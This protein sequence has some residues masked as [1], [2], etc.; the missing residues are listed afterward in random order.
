MHDGIFW[1]RDGV[2]LLHCLKIERFSRFSTYIMRKLELY[3]R[4]V[5]FRLYSLHVLVVPFDIQYRMYFSFRI[6]R[7][8]IPALLTVLFE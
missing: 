8:P 6:S 1:Q 4:S 3:V 5:H 2:L 7:L